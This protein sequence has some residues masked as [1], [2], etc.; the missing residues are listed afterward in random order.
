MEL[1][2]IGTMGYAGHSSMILESNPN[3]KL[4]AI[5][6]DQTAIDFSTE[7]LEPFKDR[8]EIR[9]GRFSAVIKDIIEEYDGFSDK[10][11]Y[12][13]ILAFHLYSLT[14]KIEVSHMRVIISI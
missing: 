12:W 5:D 1:L 11:V 10:K 6:Q 13:L 14:R 3:I 2:L 8:V 4:I 7:R 9:K